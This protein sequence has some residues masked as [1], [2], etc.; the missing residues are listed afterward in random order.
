MRRFRPLSSAVEWVRSS[1]RRDDPRLPVDSDIEVAET[2]GGAPR[3]T[4]LRWR[5]IGLVALGGTFGTAARSVLTESITVWRNI[6]VATLG[7]NILGAFLLGVL[8]EAL[9]RRGADEGIRRTLRLLLGTGFLGGFT[10]YSSLAMDTDTLARADQ[11]GAALLYAAATIIV[12]AAASALG[13][14]VASRRRHR[15]AEDDGAGCAR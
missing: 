6:P 12:G 4:H 3:P 11:P 2:P 1:V 15:L 9:T 10:T 8:L 5:Y 14:V 7:I 13:I